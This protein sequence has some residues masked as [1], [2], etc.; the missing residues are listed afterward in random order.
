MSS[1][2]IID[3]TEIIE[4][5]PEISQCLTLLQAQNSFLEADLQ[6]DADRCKEEYKWLHN[7]IIPVLGLLDAAEIERK[8]YIGPVY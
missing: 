2:K 1:V 4:H 6:E 5:M 3:A 7:G 8:R